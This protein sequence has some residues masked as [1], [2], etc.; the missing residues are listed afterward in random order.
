[1]MLPILAYGHPN[2]RKVA[3]DIDKDYPELDALIEN[4]FASMYESN[5][6]G[7][8][9]PQIN[10]S[11]RLFMVDASAYEEQHPEAKDFKRV[12]INAYIVEDSGDDYAFEEGCLS[13]PGIHEDV[14]RPPKIKM[15][16]YD[17]DWNFHTEEFDGMVARIIQHEY[18]HLEGTMF[19]DHLQPLKK[20]LLRRKLA[21]IGK[22]NVDVDYRMIFPQMKKGRR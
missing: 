6:V 18:D 10:K 22:G 5:G 14:M 9:A 8:A 3:E 16:Y 20:T 4:M 15:E 12:F 13:V 2:L 19:V 11:I 21:D 17:T 1:M 7:L